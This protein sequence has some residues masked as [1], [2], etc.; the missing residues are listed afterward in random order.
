MYWYF[1]DNKKTWPHTFPG[2]RIWSE[3]E[4]WISNKSK[5]NKKHFLIFSSV[6]IFKSFVSSYG[7]VRSCFGE[8]TSEKNSSIKFWQLSFNHLYFR[9]V[10]GQSAVGPSVGVHPELNNGQ[11]AH[12]PRFAVIQSHI[13]AVVSCLRRGFYHVSGIRCF[14]Y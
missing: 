14:S 8:F 5:L 9:S 6:G 7:P 1:S 3:Q 10:S 11:R 4:F 12:R 13:G 2:Y